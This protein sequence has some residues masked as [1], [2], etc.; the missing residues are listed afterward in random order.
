[1]AQLSYKS[2]VDSPRP[3][4]TS[5]ESG[6]NKT[7][8]EMV[9]EALVLKFSILPEE[10]IEV[11]DVAISPSVPRVSFWCRYEVTRMDGSILTGALLAWFLGEDM[12]P[13]LQFY[14]QGAH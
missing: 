8:A 5:P 11:T 6:C 7:M 2:M 3:Y 12:P 9:I 14:Q 1:M 4:R 10:K 13:V